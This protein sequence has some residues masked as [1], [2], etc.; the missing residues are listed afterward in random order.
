MLAPG[1]AFELR[2]VAGGPSSR[3]R[4]RGTAPP[5]SRARP[6]PA[7]LREAASSVRR[8]LPAVLARTVLNDHWA[9]ACSGGHRISPPGPHGVPAK[10]I[11]AS[12][13]PCPGCDG[14]P[15]P[16]VTPGRHFSRWASTRLRPASGDAVRGAASVQRACRSRGSAAGDVMPPRST[17]ASRS[18]LTQNF[19]A[20]PL[21]TP[22]APGRNGPASDRS[23]PSGT[24]RRSSG[25]CRPPRDRA[26]RCPT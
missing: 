17:K 8:R 4:S 11:A 12:S 2:R 14:N 13:P 3:L 7:W 18:S 5:E 21:V 6:A 9:N 22:G 25:C 10:A 24:F 16:V 19:L 26:G 15:L 23:R 1:A 20:A